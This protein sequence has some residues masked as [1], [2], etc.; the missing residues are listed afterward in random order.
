MTLPYR[1]TVGCAVSRTLKLS[2]GS[3]LLDA[4]LAI[5]IL[6]TTSLALLKSATSM[7]FVVARLSE[8]LKPEPA[9]EKFSCVASGVASEMRQK[10]LCSSQENSSQVTKRDTE[11]Y[12]V[13]PW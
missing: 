13:Y 12:V 4:L 8:A 6:A 10:L 9:L 3:A 1:I 5:L 11:H 7:S 2:F